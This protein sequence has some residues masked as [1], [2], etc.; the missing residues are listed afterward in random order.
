MGYRVVS[1]PL[2]A[3]LALGTNTSHL[4]AAD[5]G[6]DCCADLEER[7]AELEATTARRGN[8]KV[9]LSL[10]GFVAKQILFFDDG[11][12]SNAY[13]TDTGSI[14]IG[15]HVLFSGEAT[16]APGW[17]AGYALNLEAVNA[18]SLLVSQNAGPETG[19]ALAGGGQSIA[20]ERSYWFVKNDQLGQ[21]SVGRQSSAAD[22]QAILPDASG[23]LVVANYVLY[24]S[25]AF[26]LRRSDGLLTGVNYGSLGNCQA[27]NGAGGAVAD[28]DGI[29]NNG[30]RYD[31][32]VLFGFSA[33]ASWAEDDIWAISG[34][35][36]GEIGGFK[37]A[38]AIA[39]NESSDEAVAANGNARLNGGLDVGALQLGGYLEHLASGLFVYGAYGTEF[40]DTTAALRGAGKSS[41]DGDNWYVKA[42]WRS[43]LTPLGH[44]VFFG[45]YGQSD[46]R[47]VAALFDA[48]VDSSQLEQYGLGILQEV[49]AAA[50]SVWVSW[51]H[52]EVDDLSCTDQT[53]GSCAAFG[54]ANGVTSFDDLDIIKAGALI[55]F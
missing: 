7:I 41:P 35:Y 24:D 3:L 30:V 39:Y 6:G 40:N 50:M 10:T 44:T 13:V 52:Y 4:S 42:G 14:S 12:E 54:L 53:A 49:D 43:R 20:V 8:R 31:T 27:L 48:G 2:L 5:L 47:I 23:T 19:S 9:S 11:V 1:L 46:D 51:R 22:N 36:A 26:L 25:N 45:E 55:S 34:R 33:S 38:G 21:V 29:P 32:P 16:I 17:K 28:C 37:I 15:T 18:D